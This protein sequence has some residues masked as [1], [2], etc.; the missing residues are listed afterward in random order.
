MSK[1]EL[2]DLLT[3]L[4]SHELKMISA[5][6]SLKLRVETIERKLK[7]KHKVSKPGDLLKPKVKV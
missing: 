2:E 7:I 4:I 5:V 6:V 3:E 1:K